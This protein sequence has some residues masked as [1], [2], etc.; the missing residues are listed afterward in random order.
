[1]WVWFWTQPVP[2]VQCPDGW[3]GG[4]GL[5][6]E[7]LCKHRTLRS[8]S[9]GT[10][11][12]RKKGVQKHGKYRARPAQRVINPTLSSISHTPPVRPFDDACVA[13]SG[14]VSLLVFLGSPPNCVFHLWERKNKLRSHKQ[15]HFHAYW[16]AWHARCFTQTTSYTFSYTD[17]LHCIPSVWAWSAPLHPT[18]LHPQ[19]HLHSTAGQTAYKD[20]II[21]I[22]IDMLVELH[23]WFLF[24]QTQKHFRLQR[25][26]KAV[27]VNFH[28]SWFWRHLW[29]EA[30]WA[31]PSP[32]IK[33]LSTFVLEMQ[34]IFIYF[35]FF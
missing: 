27:S 21:K 14:F 3:T 29:T 1:M 10:C 25:K 5:P 2:A 23:R 4:C 8:P 6:G 35:S 32:V 30:A 13:L 26:F 12:G 24:I 16:Q 11:C 17:K 15:N 9:G 22:Q 20:R 31:P 18:F 7:A 19:I 33:I 28:C 34:H